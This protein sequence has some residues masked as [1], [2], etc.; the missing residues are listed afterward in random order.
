MVLCSIEG[1]T[2]VGKAFILVHGTMERKGNKGEIYE[3]P[4]HISSGS[5]TLAHILDH[6]NMSQALAHTCE[7]V[8]GEVGG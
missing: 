8:L 1:N 5:G 6:H 2:N 3:I 7:R 4:I